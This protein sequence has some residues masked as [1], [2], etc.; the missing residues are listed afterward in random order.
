MRSL[1]VQYLPILVPLLALLATTAAAADMDAVLRDLDA[2]ILSPSKT[3]GAEQGEGV[4]ASMERGEDRGVRAL[5]AP[6]M[7]F[8]P[9]FEDQNAR[10][11]EDALRQFDRERAFQVERDLRDSL[12]AQ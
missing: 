8:V 6:S 1:S 9:E 10:A 12:Q 2:K 3:R 7:V 5:A 4:A 11:K